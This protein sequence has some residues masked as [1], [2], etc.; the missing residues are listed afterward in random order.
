MDWPAFAK[1]F[2]KLTDA[3]IEGSSERWK[4]AFA[5]GGTFQ[6]PVN[7]P[8]TDYAEV[9]T[10][11]EAATPDW[12]ARVTHV[13][14]GGNSAAIEWVG[15]ATLFG[16]VPITVHGCTVFEADEGGRITRW[17]DYMDLKEIELQ[18]ADLM[19]GLGAQVEQS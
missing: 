13:A 18:A 6:D 17:R 1:E 9:V 19:K 3:R 11:T 8:T 7:G 14:A 5:P 12:H 2:E 16:K 15:E 4:A 10:Q